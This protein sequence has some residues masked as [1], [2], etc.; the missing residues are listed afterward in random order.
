[1][2]IFPTLNLDIGSFSRKIFN[3]IAATTDD[4]RPDVVNR[5]INMDVYGNINIILFKLSD[6][7]IVF[8]LDN[9][10]NYIDDTYRDG[11]EKLIYTLKDGEEWE[12]REIFLLR[13]G[14]FRLVGEHEELKKIHQL[15]TYLEIFFKENRRSVKIKFLSDQLSD[16]MD[17]LKCMHDN[18]SDETRTMMRVQKRLIESEKRN[19]VNQ[20]QNQNKILYLKKIRDKICMR[21]NIYAVL[22]IYGIP[23]L[24]HCDSGFDVDF[25]FDFLDPH[26][27]DFKKHVFE[28]QKF[29]EKQ[30]SSGKFGEIYVVDESH[31]NRI[32]KHLKR[33]YQYG[34]KELRYVCSINDLRE[35]VIDN[36]VKTK[37]V[38]K[39][40][41]N[42]CGCIII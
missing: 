23:V 6:L 20:M 14:L 19:H 8:G 31:Y 36:I 11:I 39:K 30:K 38:C 5:F 32:V 9:L 4:I 29:T 42:I 16:A 40:D 7:E 1:M 3:L 35:I 21:I 27:V 26:C 34:T 12:K 41:K 10:H 22:D 28:L 24:P 15:H 18:T 25:D 13:D 2:I 17:E 37:V 33:Y